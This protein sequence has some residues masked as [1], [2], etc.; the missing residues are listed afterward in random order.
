MESVNESVL[1][2]S[3]PGLLAAQ[4]QN[5]SNNGAIRLELGP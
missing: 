1:F 2:G 5:G 3:A 4:G